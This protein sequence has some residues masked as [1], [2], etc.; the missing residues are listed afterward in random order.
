MAGF[1]MTA[2]EQEI[3][4][5]D[6]AENFS[7]N[8]GGRYSRHGSFSGEEF[9][10]RVLAPLLKQAVEQ[11]SIL[12]V[13]ID[14][15][16]RSYQS[17]FLDEAFGGLIRDCGFS[18]DQVAKHLDIVNES[19]RFEKYRALALSFIDAAARSTIH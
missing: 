5:L 10:Q 11:D 15:V 18:A 16:H 9:R 2:A 7:A 1:N 19:P 12:R 17:S 4:M 3:P 13:R 6:V 14:T 8:P